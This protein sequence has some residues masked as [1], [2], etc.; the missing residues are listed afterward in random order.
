MDTPIATIYVVDD[1]DSLRR[2]LRRLLVSRDWKVEEFSSGADLLERGPL[3]APGCV[4]L[5]VMMPGMSGLDLQQHMVDAGNSLPVVFLSGQ[6]DIPVSV[7]AMKHGA[8]DFL[9]KPVAAEELF[10]ALDQAILRSIADARAKHSHADILSRFAQLSHREKEVLEQVVKGR[11]NKQIGFDLGIAEKTVK[12]HRARVMEK[13]KA[14]SVA[15]LVHLCHEGDI[16]LHT[17]SEM[18]AGSSLSSRNNFLHHG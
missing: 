6:S 18:V 4:L 5:D 15:E 10:Q 9:V 2:S 17:D 11:L 7:S 8:V 13:M 3:A 16:F 14:K 12:V 1:D